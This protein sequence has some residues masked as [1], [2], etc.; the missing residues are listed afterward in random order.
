M[1]ESKENPGD[2]VSCLKLVGRNAK[3]ILVLIVTTNEER[4]MHL[5]RVFSYNNFPNEDPT[6]ILD[7]VGWVVD[8]DID[9]NGDL[10]CI[11]ADG[12]LIGE[13]KA[14][15]SDMP[16]NKISSPATDG[17]MTIAG[18]AGRA[19]IIQSEDKI[20]DISAPFE[21]NLFDATCTGYNDVFV[22][23]QA[24]KFSHFSDDTWTDIH[25]PTTVNLNTVSVSKSGEVVVAGDNGFVAAGNLTNG[26]EVVEGPNFDVH[27]SCEYK[28][29]MLFA[30]PGYGITKLDK[31]GITDFQA[32]PLAW[33]ITSLDDLL[34]CAE[35]DSILVYDGSEWIGLPIT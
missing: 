23:G 31:A 17:S 20:T 4:S 19:W 5:S 14:R 29:K 2:F 34:L 6:M 18:N 8:C 12:Q 35:D 16:L 25:L 27:G 26:F 13:T 11:T 32:G 9:L 33:R 10:R 30:L 15:L 3:E 28:D 1:A 21:N 22:C 24:G 7:Y